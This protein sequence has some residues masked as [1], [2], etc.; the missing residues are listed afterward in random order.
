MAL[1]RSSE[2]VRAAQIF[3]RELEAAR[4]AGYLAGLTQA[5][6]ALYQGLDALHELLSSVHAEEP[7]E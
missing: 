7:P 1:P 5:E 6:T 2:R 3:D 4:R